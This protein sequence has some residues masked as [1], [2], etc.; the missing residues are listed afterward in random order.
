MPTTITHSARSLLLRHRYS[1]ARNLCTTASP[2]MKVSP[3]QVSWSD[4]WMYLISDDATK[5]AFVVD[6]Y[7]PKTIISEIKKTDF[8]VY[9]SLQKLRAAVYRGRGRG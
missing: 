8:K 5:E 7:D 9:W 3:I 1:S 4:N 2:R 6:P